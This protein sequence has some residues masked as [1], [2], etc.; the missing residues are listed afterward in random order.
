MTAEADEAIAPAPKPLP[1]ADRNRILFL[2][3]LQRVPKRLLATADGEV[4]PA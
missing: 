1:A 3:V 2:P 4:A